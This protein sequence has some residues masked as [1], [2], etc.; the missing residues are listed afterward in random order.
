LKNKIDINCDLGEGMANDA[1]L[2]PFISSA[3][4]ACGYHAGDSD[5]MKRT[6]DLCVQ[7]NVAIGAHPSFDDRAHFG[8]AEMKLTN[9]QLY[10]LVFSQIQL[11]DDSAKS[12]GSKLVHIKP[13]GALYNM[14][15]RDPEIACILVKAVKDFNDQLMVIGLSGSCLINEARKAGLKVANEVFADRTYTDN[16]QLT[17]RTQVNALIENVQ[18]LKK[19]ILLMI[20]SGKV[21]TTNGKQIP[22]EIDTICIHGDGPHA[23]AFAEAVY[24]TLN[25]EGI[26]TGNK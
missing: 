3:N 4:I 17:P 11:M 16:G 6:I 22:L 5:T 23:V 18:E 24:Q 21:S 1:L 8:R 14:A 15:S 13:H 20:K 26:L 10:D 7:Y 19:H 2:M 9:D 25:K 12:T